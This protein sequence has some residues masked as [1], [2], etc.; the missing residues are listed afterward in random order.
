MSNEWDD[1]A[2]EAGERLFEI[3]RDAPDMAQALAALPLAE[4]RTLHGWLLR[5]YCENAVTGVVLG[6]QFVDAAVRLMGGVIMKDDNAGG[7]E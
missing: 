4:W 7:G 5:N 1:E 2:P 3:V 6:M